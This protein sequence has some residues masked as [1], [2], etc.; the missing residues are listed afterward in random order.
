MN[1]NIKFYSKDSTVWVVYPSLVSWDYTIMLEINLITETIK[2]CNGKD[3]DVRKEILRVIN[4]ED[5]IRELSGKGADVSLI[6][7]AF[8]IIDKFGNTDKSFYDVMDM[9]KHLQSNNVLI[10][11]TIDREKGRP[12]SV[13]EI[14]EIIKENRFT[15]FF[16]PINQCYAGVTG[17]LDIRMYQHAHGDKNIPDSFGIG[18]LCPHMEMAVKVEAALHELGYKGGTENEGNGARDKSCIVYIYKIK[19]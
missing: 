5:G 12:L 19:D 4:L 14:I 18:V 13:D 9:K 3:F 2:S 7:H 17:D 11:A 1:Q 16:C 10:D 6:K 8:E 15:H